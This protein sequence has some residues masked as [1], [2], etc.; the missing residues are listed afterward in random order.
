MGSAGIECFES[1]LLLRKM[2]NS[3]TN[4]NVRVALVKHEKNDTEF[5]VRLDK[6]E[7]VA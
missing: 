7:L 6:L 1:C 5:V 3:S 2:R 4:K